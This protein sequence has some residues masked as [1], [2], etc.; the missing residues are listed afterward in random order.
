MKVFVGLSGSKMRLSIESVLRL[1][2]RKVESDPHFEVPLVELTRTREV[3]KEMLLATVRLKFL[4]FCSDRNIRPRKKNDPPA[5]FNYDGDVGQDKEFDIS[6]EEFKLFACLYGID[7]V[8]GGVELPLLEPE[9]EPTFSKLIPMRRLPRVALPSPS[10]EEI[11]ETW[12]DPEIEDALRADGEKRKARLKKNIPGKFPKSRIGKLVVK[13]AW[14]IEV[15]TGRRAACKAVMDRLCKL[16]A[17]VDETDSRDS[18]ESCLRSADTTVPGQEK[19]RWVTEA[20]LEKWFG[21]NTCKQALR[22]WKNSI[23]QKT[24]RR[25]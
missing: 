11:D 15:D 1:V 10:G 25:R 21:Q 5:C 7:V 8:T 18:N 9:A 3:R 14:E 24:I 16:A 6:V 22:V 12:D 13:I 4:G 17:T 23:P 19:V 20:G 2:L